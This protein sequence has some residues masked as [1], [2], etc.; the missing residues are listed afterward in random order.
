MTEIGIG[1]FGNIGFELGP[2]AFVVSDVLAVRADGNNAPECFDFPSGLLQVENQR[3]LFFHGILERSYVEGNP[4]DHAGL[5]IDFPDRRDMGFKR[6][7][8]FGAGE[9]FGAFDV[10]GRQRIAVCEDFIAQDGLFDLRQILVGQ[11]LSDDI[12]DPLADQMQSIVVSAA[13]DS[14]QDLDIVPFFVKNKKRFGDGGKNSLNN[15]GICMNHLH[16]LSKIVIRRSEAGSTVE[17]A[18]TLKK[19]GSRFTHSGARM[20]TQS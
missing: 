18:S 4:D 17:R 1:V 15:I 9:V 7:Q 19:L 14:S 20:A 12:M 13:I 5:A 8:S 6:L 10:S 16:N 11:F 3:I 2:V